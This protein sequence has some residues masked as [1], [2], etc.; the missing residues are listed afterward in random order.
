MAFEYQGFATL[1]VNLNR[2]KYGPLDISNV[3]TSEADLKYYLTKG[4][5]T[6]GV[7]EYWY[8]SA[9][10]KVVPYPYEGQVLA[11]IYDGVKVFV[12]KEKADGTFET[13]N[14]GDTSAVEAAVA[15]LEEAL[16]NAVA[17][18]NTK[19][20]EIPTEEKDGEQVPVAEN[21]IEYINKKTQGIATDAALGELQSAVDTLEEAVG[22]KATET[23]EASGIYKLIEEAEARAKA[24]ADENDTDTVY[25]DTAL[26]NRVTALEGTVGDAN[27]GLVKAVADNTTAIGTEKSRA[28]AAEQALEAKINEKAAQSDLTALTN[29][30]DAFLSG[31]GAAEDALDS[32]QELIAY[33]D[34]HDGADLT[35]VLATIQS[36]STKLTLGTYV[37]G[38]ET[39]EYATVKAYVEAA[40]AA[41]NIDNY[42]TVEALEAESSTLSSQISVVD[43]KASNAQK[44][45]DDFKVGHSYTDAQIED[46]ISSAITAENLSQYAKASDVVSNTDFTGYQAAVEATYATKAEVT[47]HSSNAE[48]TYAK[49]T[50]VYTTQEVDD[51][52]AGISQANTALDT[53]L[54]NYISSNDTEIAAL[55]EKD[56]AL[57]TAVEA[58]QAQA[59]KGVADAKTVADDLAALSDKVVGEG[60]LTGRVAVL[61][62]FDKDHTTNYNTLVELVNTKAN[63]GNVYTKAETDGKISGAIEAL[64]ITQYAKAADV[65]TKTAADTATSNAISGA[66]A[67]LDLTNTYITKTDSSNNIAAAIEALEIDKYITSTQSSND[68]AA[69]ISALGIGNYYTKTE[70]D[71]AF[72]TQDEVDARINTLIAASDPDGDGNTITN[73]QNLV[74]YVENH[75]SDITGIINA[76]GVKA[77]PESTEGAGDA[78]EATGLYAEI[79]DALD[80]ANAYTDELAVRVSANETAISSTIPAAIATAKSEAISTAKS[81]TLAEV[82]TKYVTSDANNNL[83][84][85]GQTI[86][87]CGGTA[88]VSS[89]AE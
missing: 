2:Q 69:A 58:A 36:L 84:L 67:A 16:A 88:E 9:T 85:N 17:A 39:K 40:I 13:A 56:T 41:L 89:A 74:E 70:A 20:G 63:S 50:D 47:A 21:V 75:G 62:Q 3:F 72:M 1:G 52:I 32:L 26:S 23:D 33:I 12:L 55:K 42:A 49:K 60:G 59:D 8:K 7:S 45:I 5:F 37:D 77:K 64:N 35:E 48:A 78:V 46:A 10:E 15:E 81:E 73:I 24:Y 71:A 65:Y 22:A 54:T 19:I 61:E 57:T 34:E 82:E 6:E 68:I 25:D 18:I 29:R 66:I 83:S 27:G 11:T 51:K 4:T 79:A 30:V 80:A 38:E 87:L 14:V 31:T 86:V 76:I 28:E 44:A 53:K 43:T